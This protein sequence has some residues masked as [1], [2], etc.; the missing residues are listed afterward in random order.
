MDKY[1][2]ATSPP[3][4]SRGTGVRPRGSNT[5]EADVQ[6]RR[7]ACAKSPRQL[8]GK[9]KQFKL[10]G[11]SDNSPTNERNEAEMNKDDNI[12]I[13]RIGYRRKY[14]PLGCIGVD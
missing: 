10:K 9:K 13:R 11:R 5:S 14:T 12:G 3:M 6:Y 1:R 4:S 8:R 2:V 7:L